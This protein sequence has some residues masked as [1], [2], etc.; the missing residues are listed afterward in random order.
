MNKIV[1]S[2]LRH[3]EITSDYDDLPRQV[4]PSPS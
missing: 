3:T 1:F 2:K 4:I